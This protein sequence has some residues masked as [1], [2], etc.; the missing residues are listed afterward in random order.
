MTHYLVTV[1]GLGISL[2]T[3]SCSLIV[4][5][6]T[7]DIMFA[8]YQ[9]ATEAYEIRQTLEIQEDRMSVTAEAAIEQASLV[10]VVNLALAATV[11]ASHSPTPVFIVPTPLAIEFMDDMNHS[12]STVD[13]VVAAP[14]GQALDTYTTTQIRES[15][16]CGISNTNSFPIDVDRVYA[17]QRLQEVSDN[18]VIG[19]EWFYGGSSVYTD[20]FQLERGAQDICVWFYLEPYSE[21]N[22]SVQFLS[23]TTPMGARVDFI[24]GD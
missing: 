5:D 10:Q 9:F 20:S 3:T 22:W 19:I 17:V 7:A 8:N 4:R 21:G 6:T 1:V 15:D 13:G 16:G 14:S 11:Y 2:L 18:T 12:S 23:N 24:V